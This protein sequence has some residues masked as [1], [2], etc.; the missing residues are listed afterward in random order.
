MLVKA[1]RFVMRYLAV[2]CIRQIAYN[3]RHHEN[4]RMS[5]G[6]RA[7]SIPVQTEIPLTVWEYATGVVARNRHL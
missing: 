2:F 5:H 1:T 4:G 7:I 3:I 6:S